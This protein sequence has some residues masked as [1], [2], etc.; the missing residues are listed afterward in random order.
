MRSLKQKLFAQIAVFA[1]AGLLIVAG[2]ALVLV[3]PKSVSADHP[4]APDHM[5][6]SSAT[7]D[8]E[9]CEQIRITVDRAC[10]GEGA[11]AM[12]ILCQQLSVESQ[13]R[14]FEAIFSVCNP[15]VTGDRLSMCR[16]VG[17][18]PNNDAIEH[19]FGG[20]SRPTSGD[21]LSGGDCSQRP[22]SKE[23]CGILDIIITLTQ[24]LSGIVGIVVVIMIAYGGIEYSASRDK[25]EIVQAAKKHIFNAL[26]A[27]VIYLFTMTFLQW[28][29]PGGLLQ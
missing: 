4:L 1:L 27:L 9:R 19:S 20:V 17:Y 13:N 5:C 11:G 7:F 29:I 23:N 14:D 26:L 28:I 2:L 3:Q 22:L 25:P 18:N 16:H 21:S 15:Q 24:I 12:Q 8:A 10:H 6:N